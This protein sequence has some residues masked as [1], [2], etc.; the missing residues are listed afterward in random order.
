[1]AVCWGSECS[2][3]IV[4]VLP[5]AGVVRRALWAPMCV[6]GAVLCSAP[7]T[8]FCL[9]GP[10]LPI[11][12]WAH[13]DPGEEYVADI[14]NTRVEYEQMIWNCASCENF[15]FLFVTKK[16]IYNFHVPMTTVIIDLLK[17]WIG[18]TLSK[19]G[20]LS[21]NGDGDWSW[22]GSVKFNRP[23][24]PYRPHCLHLWAGLGSNLFCSQPPIHCL[25]YWHL[26]LLRLVSQY[27]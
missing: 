10:L 27:D 9:V 19:V 15:A 3:E 4:M 6:R 20:V 5:D 1:M 14:S 24:S 11:T 13:S 23:I 26:G 12:P 8:A 17:I 7:L 16:N 22:L 18:N 2:T 21:G 25:P